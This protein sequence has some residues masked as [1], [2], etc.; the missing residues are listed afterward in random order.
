MIPMDT[1]RWIGKSLLYVNP[2]QRTKCSRGILGE[3]K[4]IFLE[5]RTQISYWIPKRHLENI[6]TNNTEWTKMVIFRNTH[7]YAHT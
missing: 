4:L 3:G 2:L 5:K 6:T 7:V 1:L